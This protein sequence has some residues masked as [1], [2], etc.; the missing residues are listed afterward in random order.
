MT[1]M[2]LRT[3]LWLLGEAERW[4]VSKDRYGR[5]VLGHI[6]LGEDAMWRID[7]RTE[8]YNTAE[9]AAS[10]LVKCGAKEHS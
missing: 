4:T 7:G 1:S 3:G 6:T 2:Q 8:E 9:A 10:E 5:E